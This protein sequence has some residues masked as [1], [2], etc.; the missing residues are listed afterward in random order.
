[1]YPSKRYSVLSYNQMTT[2]VCFCRKEKRMLMGY[3]SVS[4]LRHPLLLLF[5]RPHDSVSRHHPCVHSP[6]S[7]LSRGTYLS[8]HFTSGHDRWLSMYVSSQRRL[9][10]GGMQGKIEYRVYR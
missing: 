9:V 1:M 3:D 8:H 7:D 6:V 4:G 5:H 2:F 10:R